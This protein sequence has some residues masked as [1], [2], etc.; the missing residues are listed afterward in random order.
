MEQPDE[1]SAGF[2]IRLG[3]IVQEH[4]DV[5]DTL[6]ACDLLDAGALFG[7]LLTAPTLQSCCIRLEALANLAV[8]VCSGSGSLDAATATNLFERL[9]RGSIAM[10]EDPPEDAFCATVTSTHGDYRILEGIWES[11]AFYLQRTIDIV[12]RLPDERGWDRLKNAVFALLAL[13]DA[14]CDRAGLTGTLFQVSQTDSPSDD[15]L[16]AARDRVMFTGEDLARLGISEEAIAPFLFDQDLSGALLDASLQHSPLIDYPIVRADDRYVVPLPTAFSATIRRYVFGGLTEQGMRT[17]AVGLLADEYRR[18]FSNRAPLGVGHAPPI[19]FKEADEGPWVAEYAAEIEPGRFVQVLLLVDGLDGFLRG[20]FDHAARFSSI[21]VSARAAA[22]RDHAAADGNVREGLTLVVTCGIGRAAIGSR[23]DDISTEAIRWETLPIMAPDLETLTLLQVK[24]QEVLALT[25]AERTLYEHGVTIF[26]VNGLINLLA[27]ARSLDGA[28][29]DH[30]AM[31]KEPLEGHLQLLLP[32][33][34]ALDLRRERHENAGRRSAALPDGQYVTVVR[35]RDSIFADDRARPLYVDEVWRDEYGLR[36]VYVADSCDIWCEVRP[37]RGFD[38]W[39]V[40]TTWVPRVAEALDRAGLLQ[41]IDSVVFR[42]RF[43]EPPTEAATPELPSQQQIIEALRLTVDH[44][45][46]LIEVAADDTFEFGLGRT[47]NASESALVMRM[48]EGVLQLSGRAEAGLAEQLHAE[49]VTSP[50]ARQAHRFQARGFRDFVR[51]AIPDRP[52]TL[53]PIIDKSLRIGLGWRYCDATGGDEIEG[54][55]ECCDYLNVVVRGL[56][57]DLCGQ[58]RAFDRQEVLQRLLLTHEA[59]MVMQQRYRETARANLALHPDEATTLRV[60]SE[61]EAENNAVLLA[62]RVLAELA[63]CEC[64]PDEG[65]IPGDTDLSLWL[66]QLLMAINYGGWSDAMHYEAM[67]ASVVIRP[68]GDIHANLDFVNEVAEPFGHAAGKAILRGSID[69]YEK[70]FEAPRFS[71]NGAAQLDPDFAEAWIIETGVQIDDCRRFID[72][73]EDKA[74]ASGQAVMAMKKSQLG[75]IVADEVADWEAVARFFVLKTRPRWRDLPTESDEKDFQPWRFRRKL[76]LLRRPILQLDD[77]D[78][79]LLMVAPGLLRDGFGF[80]FSGYYEGSFPHYQLTS[81]Q[82][83]AWSGAIANKRGEEFAQAVAARML[84][85][86]WNAD[87]EVQVR[88]IL[89][90]RENDRYGDLDVLAWDPATCRILLLECKD[91]HFH[92]SLGE[93]AEQVRDYRGIQDGKKRDDMLKHIDRTNVLMAHIPLLQRYLK[94]DD[95]PSIRS[96]IVFRHPVPMVHVPSDAEGVVQLTTFD[97]LKSIFS[98][99]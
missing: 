31:G 76:S 99:A 86:G 74:I 3:R 65:L 27:H 29:I 42:L 48:F 81:P 9:G 77:E 35:E 83:T 62:S 63:L 46:G 49:V 96:F 50:F 14:I 26:N 55:R 91:L 37:P 2:G 97:E 90:R 53:Q 89:P 93:M 56:L 19:F 47:D 80:T 7:G 24:P 75:Q 71:A 25:G 20:G 22:F 72:L 92:K 66:S 32:P 57:D 88:R 73:V 98:L 1:A 36:V 11:S 45:N 12:E 18:L 51:E 84:E 61:K 21:D 39:Q 16:S 4:G 58:L 64:V 78:D 40:A 60:L 95:V 28:L 94:L 59:A 79:P 6:R 82:M 5:L 17:D 30:A 54:K 69:G 87:A 15:L 43:G 44:D 8:A 34:L 41:A 13:S 85:L 38:R 10:L 33:E 70:N 23:P 67:E 68:L 52:L